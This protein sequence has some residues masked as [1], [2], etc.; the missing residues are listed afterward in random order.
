MMQ[1]QV[2]HNYDGA[3]IMDDYNHINWYD[4]L[5]DSNGYYWSR[6][7]NFL[8]QEQQFGL[9]IVNKLE[10]ETLKDLMNFIGDPSSTENF[11]K[12]RLNNRRCSIRQNLYI[13]RL[14]M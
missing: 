14:D 6:Y 1:C 12:K 2:K 5:D 3:M 4:N 10:Q 11:F 9:N 13:Y 7:R 8:L